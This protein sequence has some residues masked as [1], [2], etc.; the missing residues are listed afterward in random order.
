MLY[1]AKFM[2]GGVWVIRIFRMCGRAWSK[3]AGLSILYHGD[4]SGES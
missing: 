4:D 1:V 2:I 3:G